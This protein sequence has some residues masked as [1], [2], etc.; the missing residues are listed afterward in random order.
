[1][2]RGAAGLETLDPMTMLPDLCHG[3]ERA[4]EPGPDDV[5]VASRVELREVAEGS[6]EAHV[7]GLLVVRIEVAH[8]RAGPTERE[9]AQHRVNPVTLPREWD[10]RVPDGVVDV[11]LASVLEVDTVPRDVKPAPEADPALDVRHVG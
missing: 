11:V 10:R 6:G 1:A 5:A 3:A 4:M 7:E 2:E 9:L 8:S